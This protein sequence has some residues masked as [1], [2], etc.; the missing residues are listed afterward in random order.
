MHTF[1]VSNRT[2]IISA[3]VVAVALAIIV[4]IE[5][6]WLLNLWQAGQ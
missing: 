2:L 6:K 4:P 3:A 1:P 5:A